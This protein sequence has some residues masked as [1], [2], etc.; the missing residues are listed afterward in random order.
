MSP[1]SQRLRKLG[2]R[3]WCCVINPARTKVRKRVN[4]RPGLWNAIGAPD[5]FFSSVPPRILTGRIWPSVVR[6][7]ASVVSDR[8]KHSGQP[9]FG[10]EPEVSEPFR[11]VLAANEQNK[12]ELVF[13]KGAVQS[14][15]LTPETIEPRP[16]CNVP[17]P[18]GPG[19]I[20]SALRAARRPIY[21]P[22]NRSTGVGLV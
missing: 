20:G 17:I 9:R 15:T 19:Y 6:P 8:R 10:S 7:C 11:K 21:L 12:E 3:A 5:G 1:N 2:Y 22:Y 18:T 4:W 13:D 16:F 14:K